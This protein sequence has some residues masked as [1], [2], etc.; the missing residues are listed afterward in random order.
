MNFSRQ[1]SWMTSPIERAPLKRMPAKP[2]HG[3]IACTRGAGP[4]ESPQV[5]WSQRPLAGGEVI[6]SLLRDE[7]IYGVGWSF[8]SLISEMRAIQFCRLPGSVVPAT[9][10]EALSLIH[11]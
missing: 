4:A 8:F 6:V 9:A 2:G 10:S 5:T 11:I 1:R 3:C 7:A